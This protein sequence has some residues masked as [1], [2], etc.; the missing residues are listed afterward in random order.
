MRIRVSIT[1]MPVI[2]GWWSRDL[3]RVW[4]EYKCHCPLRYKDY[5]YKSPQGIFW[6]FRNR[7]IFWPQEW[8]RWW[9]A[10]FVLCEAQRCAGNCWLKRTEVSSS[11]EIL[12]LI[13]R[14][15]MCEVRELIGT[16]TGYQVQNQLKLERRKLENVDMWLGNKGASQGLNWSLTSEAAV[17]LRLNWARTMLRSLGSAPTHPTP[18]PP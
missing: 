7:G 12:R 2:V 15:G 17:Q 3:S 5:H 13:S 6:K 11:R 14:N 16:C 8:S 9:R 18:P 10:R 4:G 1:Y